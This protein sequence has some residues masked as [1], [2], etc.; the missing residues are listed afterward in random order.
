VS[1]KKAGETFHDVWSGAEVF[2]PTNPVTV[3]IER[4]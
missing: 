1:S 4:I 2:D 3:V